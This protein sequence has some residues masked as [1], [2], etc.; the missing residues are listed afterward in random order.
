MRKRLQG[1][2]LGLILGAGLVAG[3]VPASGEAEWGRAP[4]QAK[5]GTYL[6]RNGYCKD[7]KH[8]TPVQVFTPTSAQYQCKQKF[9]GAPGPP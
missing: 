7:S 4:M 6:Y 9:K 1:L 5:V 2:V 3:L 8:M